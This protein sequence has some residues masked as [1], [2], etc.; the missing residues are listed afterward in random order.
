LNPFQTILNKFLRNNDRL[1]NQHLSC[2][3]SPKSKAKNAED[4]FN[5]KIVSSTVP[6]QNNYNIL[7]DMET[8][9]FLQFSEQLISANLSPS[10][11]KLTRLS[12]GGFNVD[13]SGICYVG[14]INLYKPPTKYVVIKP[15]NKRATKVFDFLEDANEFVSSHA[16]YEIQTRNTVPSLYMQ[17][18][19]GLSTIKELNNTS[20]NE[21]IDHIPDWIRY[22][23]YCMLN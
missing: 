2:N 23:K 12:N 11:I 7:N 5:M 14:K 15:G 13:Y 19:K 9:F 8:Q 21:C 17:Y 22:I 3:T 4:S 10:C 16:E 6:P 20:L 1:R 18:L